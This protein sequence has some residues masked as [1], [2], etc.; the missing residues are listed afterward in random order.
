VTIS[1]KQPWPWLALT[2][3]TLLI[4]ISLLPAT[5]E[6]PEPSR[7]YHWVAV[8]AGALIGYLGLDGVARRHGY[9]LP[10]GPLSRLLGLILVI[11]AF[12]VAFAISVPLCG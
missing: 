8:I 4:G 3:G 1:Q 9:T 12:G 7:W 11:P 6:P 10:N 5:C 2:L